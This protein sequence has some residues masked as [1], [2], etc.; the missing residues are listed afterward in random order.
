M[1]K[2]IIKLFVDNLNGSYKWAMYRKRQLSLNYVKLSSHLQTN[3][4]NGKDTSL[5]AANTHYLLWASNNSPRPAVRNITNMLAC[6]TY[7]HTYINLKSYVHTYKHTHIHTY[8]YIHIYA[9]I[10]YWSDVTL[11]PSGGKGG[12]QHLRAA[13]RRVCLD[14]MGCKSFRERG[15]SSDWV[16]VG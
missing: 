1:H 14:I 12:S 11:P 8:I 15:Q 10:K 3:T 13:E 4:D 16:R 9:H 5:F 6:E 7:L 2:V